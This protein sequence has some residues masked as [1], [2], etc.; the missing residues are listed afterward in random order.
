MVI[1]RVQQVDMNTCALPY[2]TFP[3]LLAADLI[4]GK[5]AWVR[6]TVFRTMAYLIHMSHMTPSYVIQHDSFRICNFRPGTFAF[7]CQCV[8]RLR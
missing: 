1:V 3:N 8:T 5:I 6:D 2:N 7:M 4:L